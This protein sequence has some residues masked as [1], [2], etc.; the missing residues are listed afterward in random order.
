MENVIQFPHPTAPV[1]PIAHFI[2]LGEWGYNKLANL[3]AIGRL[4]ARRV[5]VDAS[6]MKHQKS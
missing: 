6:R 2:R 4:P 3:H 1:Q 5:V